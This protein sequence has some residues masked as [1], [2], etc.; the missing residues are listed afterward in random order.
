MG[1]SDDTITI[2]L[3]SI[4][5]ADGAA[6]RAQPRRGRH[7]DAAARSEP[8][9]GA[10]PGGRVLLYAPNPVDGSSSISHWDS[11]AF[12]NLLMQ[13]NIAS[14]L[15]H[16]V[17]LTLPL[18]QDLGWSSEAAIPTAPP[19]RGA[20][21]GTRGAAA[22][23]RAAPLTPRG[24]RWLQPFA[25]FSMLVPLAVGDRHHREARDA[26]ERESRLNAALALISASVTGR[27]ELLHRHDVDGVEL[28]RCVLR[29]GIRVVGRRAM[30]TTAFSS[31][32]W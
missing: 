18:L 25:I 4:T 21:G 11:S 22:D 10:D 5:Q 3:V 19:R 15:Q 2:P 32:V 31:P 26:H 29:V 27:G 20:A 9:A 14:D 1:G 12:P 17:D 6:L 7:G 16:D 30:P 8:P 24:G 28:P 13:P 23:G